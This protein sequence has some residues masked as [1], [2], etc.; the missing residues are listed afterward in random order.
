MPSR[1]SFLNKTDWQLEANRAV[2][3]IHDMQRYFVD[4]YDPDS[5]LLPTLLGNIAKIKDWANKNIPIVYT[6]IMFNTISHDH[7]LIEDFW[8]FRGNLP[9]QK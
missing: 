5:V 9:V 6:Q 7:P 4:I 8:G 2:L 3:L 1:T